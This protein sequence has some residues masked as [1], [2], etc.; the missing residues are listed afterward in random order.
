MRFDPKQLD[1]FLE[2]N[3][4]S[5]FH[6]ILALMGNT[7]IQHYG[8]VEIPIGIPFANRLPK[9]QDVVGYFVNS[10]AV[11]ISQKVTATSYSAGLFNAKKEDFSG[12]PGEER[13]REMIQLVKR[14]IFEAMQH[15][16]VPFELIVKNINPRRSLTHHPIFQNMLSFE[17]ASIS[18]L[19]SNDFFIEE[20][21]NEKAKFDQTWHVN[22]NFIDQGLLKLKIE[23][24]GT[25]LRRKTIL[26]LL[27]NFEKMLQEVLADKNSTNIQKIDKTSKDALPDVE[28][29]VLKIWKDA[30][31]VEEIGLDDNFFD[32]GGHSLLAAT[33]CS[34]IQTKLNVECPVR[35]VFQYQTVREMVEFLKIQHLDKEKSRDSHKFNKN[36]QNLVNMTL[37]NALDS[38]KDSERLLSSQTLHISSQNFYRNVPKL[39]Q[40]IRLKLLDLINDAASNKLVFDKDFNPE[41]PNPNFKKFNTSFK[42]L[43]KIVA[44][45]EKRLN[46]SKKAMLL[47]V[48]G[49]CMKR[50]IENFNEGF[51]VGVLDVK[52][53]ERDEGSFVFLFGKELKNK[54]EKFEVKKV[55]EELEKFKSLGEG[56]KKQVDMVFGMVNKGKLTFY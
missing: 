52:D 45:L 55:E 42:K 3:E 12:D 23:F 11:K 32:I 54:D 29:E 34:R 30:L 13:V 35:V 19:P 18:G 33:I 7:L 14:K 4:C 20:V 43:N 49:E 47:T 8:L 6:L 40:E 1:R 24:D 27:E 38:L 37:S 31:K 25:I 50:R 41:T 22:P 5:L 51:N 53:E 36:Q 17:N 16:E 10:H 39:D 26:K 2:E 48:F 56:E 44:G 21:P 9:F 28:I 15:S 46:F